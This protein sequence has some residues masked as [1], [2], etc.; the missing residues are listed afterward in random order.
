VSSPIT[1][2]SPHTHHN[3]THLPVICTPVCTNMTYVPYREG[4]AVCVVC[5]VVHIQT[6]ITHTITNTPL[7]RSEQ[8]AS[9]VSHA[10]GGREVC[11]YIYREVYIYIYIY[12]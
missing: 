6:M 4:R 7:L 8:G 12:L 9:S 3:T 1:P 11:I 10:Y 2:P 5:A